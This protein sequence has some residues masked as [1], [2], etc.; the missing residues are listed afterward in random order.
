MVETVLFF[1]GM[2][3]QD[4]FAQLLETGPVVC[5]IF[6]NQLVDQFR[7]KII[8]QLKGFFNEDTGHTLLYTLSNPVVSTRKIPELD[9][10]PRPTSITSWWNPSKFRRDGDQWSMNV[11][12]SDWT[13]KDFF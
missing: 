3:Y 1:P 9:L 10:S 2:N 5:Q 12:E 4:M 6:I 7:D 13:A 8:C 11:N